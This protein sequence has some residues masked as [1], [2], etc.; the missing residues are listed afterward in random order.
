M[1]ARLPYLTPVIGLVL[2]LAAG[3]SSPVEASAADQPTAYKTNCSACHDLD[4]NGIGPRH[5]GLF[6]RKS[7][8]L[9]DYN[10]SPALKAAAIS[11]NRETLD[12]WLKG[13]RKVVP[14][15]RMIKAVPDPVIR[16]EI[17]DYLQEAK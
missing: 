4:R 11:W 16:R 7:G 14:G 5:R 13:P 12:N 17:I 8:S 3:A 10:Y 1:R 15:T 6:G 2:A 9:P